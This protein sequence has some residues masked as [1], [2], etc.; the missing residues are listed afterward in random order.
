MSL[1]R[2]LSRIDRCL[3]AIPLTGA[4]AAPHEDRVQPV[5][6]FRSKHAG[7]VLVWHMAG[8]Y[9]VCTLGD[10]LVAIALA[11]VWSA[12]AGQASTPRI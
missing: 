10:A 8:W 1:M 4:L 3:A 5:P 7:A 2:A 12:A 9:A 6:R 11:H